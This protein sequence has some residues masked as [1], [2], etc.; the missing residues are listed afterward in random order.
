[1]ATVNPLKKSSSYKEDI[2]KNKYDDY[3]ALSAVKEA[4][5]YRQSKRRDDGNKALAPV[6]DIHSLFI[7]SPLPS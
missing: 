6:W 2:E 7:S 3:I 1:M 4:E 5:A